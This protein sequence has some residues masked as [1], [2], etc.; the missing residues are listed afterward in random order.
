MLE[1]RLGL[2]RATPGVV[3]P[4]ASDGLS[5]PNVEMAFAAMEGKGGLED[6]RT[7]SISRR[8]S[9]GSRVRGSRSHLSLSQETKQNVLLNG[10]KGISP[11]S[12]LPPSASSND[13]TLNNFVSRFTNGAKSIVSDRS[14]PQF[15]GLIAGRRTPGSTPSKPESGH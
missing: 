2:G 4:M 15:Q 12:E 10:G 6:I 11:A 14:S 5:M 7:P 13:E 1:E 8:V 3:G 9:F